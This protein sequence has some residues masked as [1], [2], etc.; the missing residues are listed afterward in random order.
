MGVEVLPSILFLHICSLEV[1]RMASWR[2]ADESEEW[3][4]L[5]EDG[6]AQQGQEDAAWPTFNDDLTIKMFTMLESTRGD[7]RILKEVMQTHQASLGSIQEDMSILKEV[8]QTMRTHQAS[9]FR[10]SVTLGEQLCEM[11]KKQLAIEA[12]NTKQMSMLIQES[13][14]LTDICKKMQDS[15]FI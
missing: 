9:V 13:R 7:M 14:A 5:A 4:K 3:W 10:R 8:C 11:Q 6:W 2:S 12:T 1:Y 15:S